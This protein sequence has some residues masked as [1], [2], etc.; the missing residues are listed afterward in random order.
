MIY[1]R[2]NALPSWSERY[3]IWRSAF[4]AA[5]ERYATAFMPG[6][7]VFDGDALFAVSSVY[8]TEP[9]ECRLFENHRKYMDIQML[10]E[11]EEQIDVC[12]PEIETAD[13]NYRAEGDIEFHSFNTKYSSVLLREGDFLLLF[14]GEWHRPCIHAG[15]GS[16]LCKKIVIKVDVEQMLSAERMPVSVGR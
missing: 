13:T 3:P 5:A 11:G 7:Y 2:I 14:P 1:D 15:T 12:L 9:R 10:V 16:R 8:E 4:L 6:K